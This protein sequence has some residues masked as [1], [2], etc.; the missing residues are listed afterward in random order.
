MLPCTGLCGCGQRLTL[1]QPPLGT[2]RGPV[3]PWSPKLSSSHPDAASPPT[4][5]PPLCQDSSHSALRVLL[6]L[7]WTHSLLGAPSE[8]KQSWG[9]RE[10]TRFMQKS[11]L[12][13]RTLLNS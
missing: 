13:S 12:H 2:T 7:T 3:Q 10:G 8:A 11:R 4:P 5:P 6:A 9:Q 1:P